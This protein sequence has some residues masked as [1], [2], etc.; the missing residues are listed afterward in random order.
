MIRPFLL[1]GSAA[2]L[3]WAGFRL[4]TDEPK[5]NK[6]DSDKKATPAVAPIPQPIEP[7]AAAPVSP[8]PA[9][10]EGSTQ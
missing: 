1:I 9:T 7:P 4:L 2:C 10:I 6:A 5:E 8:E 3:L